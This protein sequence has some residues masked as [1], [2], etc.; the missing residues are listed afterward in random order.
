M[1]MP[2]LITVISFFTCSQETKIDS[3]SFDCE[4]LLI[5]GNGYGDVKHYIGKFDAY[6][7]TY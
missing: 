4:A 3:Y 2:W 7:R 5:A 1:L 6:Q